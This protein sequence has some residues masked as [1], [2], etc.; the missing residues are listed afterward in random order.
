M[1]DLTP[2]FK[3]CVQIIDDEIARDPNFKRPVAKDLDSD[4]LERF[5]LKDTFVKECYDLLNF[6]NGA[7]QSSYH[8]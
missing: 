7:P 1:G 3:K 6:L 5:R 4:Q 2:L 8:H